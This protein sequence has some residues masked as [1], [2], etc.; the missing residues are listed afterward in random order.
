MLINGVLLEDLEEALRLV[1]NRGASKV[2]IEAPTGFRNVAIEVAKMIKDVPVFI[3][4]RNTWGSCDISFNSN[5][6]IIHLGHAVPPNIEGILRMN[7]VTLTRRGALIVINFKDSSAYLVPAYYEPNRDVIKALL[8][9]LELV[10]GFELMAYALP[11]KLY[12]EEISQ[13]LGVKLYG[14]FT[15]CFFPVRTNNAAVVS[16]GLFY[17]LTVKLVNPAA[18]VIAVDPHRV[19]VDD[20]EQAYRKLLALKINALLKAREAKRIAVIV[21]G[22]PGQSMELQADGVLKF[23]K[24][25]GIE[26]FI[27]YS[28]EVGPDLVNELSVDAVINTA[29]PRLGFDD[30]D[31]FNKPVINMG[32]IQYLRGEL[33]RYLSSSV[34]IWPG[35]MGE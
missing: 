2:I 21:T 27:V 33:G 25:N 30:L 24:K 9:K 12:A 29:C 6:A 1:S 11:Y 7:G 5:A 28:D 17:P 3:S 8:E 34:L 15:G 14:P 4:G 10:P 20:V 19:S 13:S 35:N 18:R 31:R 22:K 23:L 32:E 16:G 26:S